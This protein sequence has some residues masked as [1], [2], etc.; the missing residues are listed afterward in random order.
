MSYYTWG[1]VQVALTMFLTRYEYVW[2]S[3]DVLIDEGVGG[4]WDFGTLGLWDSFR[5]ILME[6]V[7]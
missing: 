7:D 2:L 6:W 3:F 1:G 4:D 5:L